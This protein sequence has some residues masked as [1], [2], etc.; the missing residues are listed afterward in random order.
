V[1]EEIWFGWEIW[2]LVEGVW[3]MLMDVLL[4]CAREEE[5][6]NERNSSGVAEERPL[7]SDEL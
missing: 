4:W 3:L 6:R 2:C 1:P 7:C 5:K